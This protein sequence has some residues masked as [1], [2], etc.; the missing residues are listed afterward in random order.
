MVC[1]QELGQLQQTLSQGYQQGILAMIQVTSGNIYGS[2]VIVQ[3]KRTKDTFKK[4]QEHRNK[5]VSIT[6]YFTQFFVLVLTCLNEKI[7]NIDY[8]L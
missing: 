4:K 2:H 7:E 3:S 6:N 8:S 5:K 1:R